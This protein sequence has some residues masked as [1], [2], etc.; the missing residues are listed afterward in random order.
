[1]VRVRDQLDA[2]D[3]RGGVGE[4]DAEEAL[5][6]GQVCRQV[7]DREGGGVAAD[8]RVRTSG[9]LDALQ[10]RALDL[11]PLQHGFLDQIRLG[12]RLGQAVG[13]AQV[14]PD[15]IGR[16]G[17]EEPLG[18][19]VLGF[20]TQPVEVATGQGGIGVDDD[21]V[22]AG[23]RKDLGDAA[24]HVAGADD[25]DVLDLIRHVGHDLP[26]QAPK[27]RSEGGTPERAGPVF[28]PRPRM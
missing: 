22:E 28:G 19:E 26:W 4:V 2:G 16:T 11:R 27:R 23:H 12:D 24:T 14:G 25:R 8:D 21:H 3:E 7:A 17:L 10:H 13:C 6:T 18:L 15:S 9:C 1:M 20:A 5:G